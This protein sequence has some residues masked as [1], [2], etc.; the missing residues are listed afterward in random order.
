MEKAVP[1]QMLKMTMTARGCSM[2]QARPGVCA[3]AL[4]VP[5]RRSSRAIHRKETTEP[6]MTQAASTTDSRAV[7]AHPPRRRVD[8]ARAKPVTLWPTTPD[9]ATNSTVTRREFQKEGSRRVLR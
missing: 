1:H 6:G 2:S 3:S 5:P 7:R 9:R 8:Q 4:S